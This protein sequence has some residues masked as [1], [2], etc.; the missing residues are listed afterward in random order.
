MREKE[1]KMM[2]ISHIPIRKGNTEW[3]NLLADIKQTR[4]LAKAGPIYTDLR[5]RIMFYPKLPAD[6][7]LLCS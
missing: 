1:Q 2:S 6:N 7:P 5:K 4:K 3:R